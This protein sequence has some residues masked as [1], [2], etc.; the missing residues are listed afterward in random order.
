MVVRY[1]SVADLLAER[2]AKRPM[3]D[4]VAEYVHK[5]RI[6]SSPKLV[7][8]EIKALC[9][10]ALLDA[11]KPVNDETID[12][13]YKVMYPAGIPSQPQDLHTVKSRLPL[14]ETV[15]PAEQVNEALAK[16]ANPKLNEHYA[17]FL[18]T[19]GFKW[20][21]TSAALRLT[22]W[23]KFRDSASKV[24]T[25]R[26]R[27]L[28]EFSATYGGDLTKLSAIDRLRLSDC[29]DSRKKADGYHAPNWGSDSEFGTELTD[30]P[31]TPKKEN[32]AA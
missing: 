8:N 32:E 3:A 7:E 15:R 22:L 24:E 4:R 10:R 17:K 31:V 19:T 18:Q 29:S 23:N 28:R 1:R 12:Q 9:K 27:L 26:A 21:E 25:D 6:A 5:Q 14:L 11:G 20:E 2:D 30:V 16:G 13:Y